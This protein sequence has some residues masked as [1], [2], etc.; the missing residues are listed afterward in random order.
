[1]M[2]FA[3]RWQS[4]A[5]ARQRRPADSCGRTRLRN[6]EPPER[7]A[8][9]A[10][11]PSWSMLLR[12]R[13]QS[14]VRMEGAHHDGHGFRNRRSSRGLD[15]HH[16]SSKEAYSVDTLYSG[17]RDPCRSISFVTQG[18]PFDCHRVSGALM[19]SLDRTVASE[20]VSMRRQES[21]ELPS[22]IF[23]AV[24]SGEATVAGRLSSRTGT[25]GPSRALRGTGVCDERTSE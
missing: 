7:E 11:C 6:K 23:R 10:F 1:M 15:S 3:L 17:V 22:R 14:P 18:L 19:L 16:Q 21:Y 13:Q 9:L 5:A 24:L 4:P 25:G 12:M 2:T 20:P 8:S